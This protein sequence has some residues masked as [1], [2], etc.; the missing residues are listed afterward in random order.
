MT[1]NAILEDVRLPKRRVRVP[2]LRDAVQSQRHLAMRAR[3]PAAG[4]FEKRLSRSNRRGPDRGT[5]EAKA[6]TR[7]FSASLF[8]VARL[9][10]ARLGEF[11]SLS[12][13]PEL[14]ERRLGGLAV[15]GMCGARCLEFAQLGQLAIEF[16]S[17]DEAAISLVNFDALKPGLVVPISPFVLAVL[18]IGGSAQILRSVVDA[19]VV[20]MIDF[21]RVQ[22]C[23]HLV[24][25]TVSAEFHSIEANLKIA[26]APKHL[27]RA[28]HSSSVSGIAHLLDVLSH[29]APR[30]SEMADG[31]IAPAQNPARFIVDKTLVKVSAVWQYLISLHAHLPDWRLEAA[32]SLAGVRRFAHFSPSRSQSQ[33]LWAILGALN[34]AGTPDRR[35]D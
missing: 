25:D 30:C 3:W 34:A 18:S 35:K 32:R 29:S 5:A 4:G 33:G 7:T 9:I 15:S 1:R 26:T 10:W 24:D 2:L 28:G 6:K 19:V 13:V 23:Q 12:W 16:D 17:R 14:T 20:P 27:K 8:A 31:S 11:A 21:W 22:P